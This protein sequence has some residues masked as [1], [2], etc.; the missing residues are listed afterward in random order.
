MK[1][2]LF[3]FYA[4]L[5]TVTTLAQQIPNGPRFKEIVGNKL[6]IGTFLQSGQ[7]NYSGVFF[8]PDTDGYKGIF[9]REF[10]TA[11]TAWFNNWGGWNA[12]D[13]F[14]F[15]NL[16]K[17]TDYAMANNKYMVMH[18]GVAS[19]N[20]FQPKWLI[21]SNYT[22][23]E[24]DVLL[25]KII[26][27]L[28]DDHDNKNKYAVLNVANEL[29]NEDGSYRDSTTMRWNKMGWENDE[30]D[31]AGAEK[32]NTKHPI[33]VGKTFQYFREKTNAIL[34]LREYRND[35]I[36]EHTSK[37]FINKQRAFYQLAKH[38][39]NKKIPIDAV[40]LQSHYYM[41][42]STNACKNDDLSGAMQKF[43]KLGLKVYVTEFDCG[44]Y[45]DGKSPFKPFT[46]EKY[47]Q[48]RKEYYELTKQMLKGEPDMICFWG[49]QDADPH[50]RTK[51]YHMPFDS[52]LNAKPA[53]YGIQQALMEHYGKS[54]EIKKETKVNITDK[55]NTKLAA[56]TPKKKK[57]KK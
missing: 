31:L 47:Q 36:H 22:P 44:Q 1:K 37:R 53:Y 51:E 38:L 35:I 46:P 41:G 45:F 26:Y 50:W 33:F 18:C 34:E 56:N 7:G 11:Q 48:Q 39:L 43:K 28:M 10:N 17:M 5:L 8:G 57:R 30:S 49:F 52:V 15:S 21:D 42:D 9:N 54:A 2:S 3:L 29:F 4:V 12:P 20:F 25:K 23:T 40:G 16:R 55:H 13:Q 19:W 32:V 24:L 6:K 27:A 14:N